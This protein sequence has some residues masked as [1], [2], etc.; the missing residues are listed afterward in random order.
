[1]QGLHEVAAVFAYIEAGNQAASFLLLPLKPV[2]IP[3]LGLN[4][5]TAGIS[6][7]LWFFTL[8]VSFVPRACWFAFVCILWGGT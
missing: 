8:G 1:M 2:G 3:G 5:S 7:H 4:G 6:F